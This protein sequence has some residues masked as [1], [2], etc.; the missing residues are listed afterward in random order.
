MA[1][2]GDPLADV[3]MQIMYWAGRGS[4]TTPAAPGI[5]SAGVTGLPGFMTRDEAIARYAER[6][7]RDVSE[8]DFYVVLA[9]FKLAVILEGIHAR[10]LEGGTVGA[11]FETMAE[12]VLML[13]RSG[14]AVADASSIKALNG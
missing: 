6:S 9:Y 13:A 4:A 14:M 12:Q 5:A 8:L 10:F 11:G 7:G 2:L 3:G 1:T